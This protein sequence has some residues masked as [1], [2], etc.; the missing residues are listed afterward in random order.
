MS[1][2]IILIAPKKIQGNTI[3]VPLVMFA[4]GF[5]PT[6]PIISKTQNNYFNYNYFTMTSFFMV[7]E[8]FWINLEYPDEILSLNRNDNH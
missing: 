6:I 3:L 2:G 1:F 7:K 5:H 4:I 8:H